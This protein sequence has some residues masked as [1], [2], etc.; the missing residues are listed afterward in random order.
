M[1]ILFLI[2]FKGF[3]YQ[4]FSIPKDFLEKNNIDVDVVSNHKGIAESS[5]GE[6]YKVDKTIDEININ[7]YDA[8]LIVGGPGTPSLRSDETVIELVKNFKNKV[9]GAICWAPTILAKA[10][11]VKKA[12]VWKGPDK[13]YNCS[14][15]NVLKHFGVKYTGKTVE[16]D[17]NIVTANGPNAALEFAQIFYEVL[18]KWK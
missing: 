14:T 18:K 3:Q 16:I 7:D 2:A 4:E 1:N 8:L 6:T 9:I 10:G 17:N 12:T 15:D 11:V 13:E 5:S